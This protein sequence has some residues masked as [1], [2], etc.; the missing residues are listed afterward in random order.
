[1]PATPIARIEGKH[2]PFQNNAA[3]TATMVAGAESTNVVTITGQ[4][5]DAR[6]RLMERAIALQGWIALSATTF[7]PHA[8]GPNGGVA[9]TVGSVV[10]QV[11]NKCFTV[12]TNATGAFTL[13]ATDSGAFTGFLCVRMPDGSIQVSNAIT[14]T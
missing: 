8:N 7:A 2:N 12:V 6:G 9:A 4:V 1:M 5:R 10:T 3:F 11:A 13:T 14:T